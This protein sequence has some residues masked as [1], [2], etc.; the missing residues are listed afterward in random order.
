MNRECRCSCDSVAIVLRIF[1]LLS[2]CA[3]GAA[4]GWGFILAYRTSQKEDSIKTAVDGSKGGDI[5]E[6]LKA[7]NSSQAVFQG[8][9]AFYFCIFGI[10][11]I[12][13]ELRSRWINGNILKHLGFLKTYFGRA[14]FM[15]YVGELR[16][17]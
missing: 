12:L 2:H 4:G 9:M 7:L 17:G 16:L 6:Y 13:S 3:S 15:I 14:C 11:G 8:I 10:L 5:A 1:S